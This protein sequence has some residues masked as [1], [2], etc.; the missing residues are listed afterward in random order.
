MK[1][2]SAIAGFGHKIGNIVVKNGPTIAVVG[3]S[4][5]AIAGTFLACKATLKA[6]NVLDEHKAQMDIIHEA[7][8]KSES[9]D[10]VDYT[11]NDK[12]KDTLQV[13]ASTAGK[14]ARLYAPAVGLEVAGFVAI[15]W[16]F[17]LIS[18]RY[19]LA[20]GA[21]ASLDEKF[22]QYRGN[23]IDEYGTDVDKRLAG[24]LVLGD[25]NQSDEEEITVTD[26]EGNEHSNTAK[27]IDIDAVDLNNFQFVFQKYDTVVDENGVTKTVENPL[28]ESSYLYNH[29]LIQQVEKGYT[30]LLQNRSI[31][32]LFLNKV[33]REFGKNGNDFGHYYGWTSKPGCSVFLKA[34]PFVRVWREEDSEQ[35]PM[36]IFLPV[37]YDVDDGSMIFINKEDEDLY[38]NT[39]QTNDA[40]V[41][42][43][44]T[45]NIDCDDAGIPH[46]IYNEVYGNKANKEYDILTA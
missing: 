10:T 17:G 36:I 38:Y 4:V 26:S 20:L 37:D 3:G 33:R 31:D 19:G 11:E 14:F 5:A 12:K 7:E 23:V 41:G 16:G 24:E 44:L 34:Q 8:K 2:L 30:R 6:G 46:E 28:W 27:K 43:V 1:V 35:F 9:V 18:R 15:F 25:G 13:Y 21:I 45:P 22:R 40:N 39:Y 29:N 42:Y 32:H